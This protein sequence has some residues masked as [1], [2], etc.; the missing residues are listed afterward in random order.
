MNYNGENVSFFD[1]WSVHQKCEY[2]KTYTINFFITS[3]EE[4]INYL[5]FIHYQ[6][7]EFMNIHEIYPN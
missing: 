5:S 4:S 7:V 6:V 1:Y 3:P 2:N